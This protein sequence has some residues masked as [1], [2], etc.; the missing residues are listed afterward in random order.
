MEEH[1]DMKMKQLREDSSRTKSL[2][3]KKKEYERRQINEDKDKTKRIEEAKQKKS[4]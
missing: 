4:K 2:E 1:W 3:E